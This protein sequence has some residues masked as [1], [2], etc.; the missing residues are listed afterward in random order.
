MIRTILLVILLHVRTMKLNKFIFRMQEVFVLEKRY[1]QIMTLFKL[2]LFILK[3][4]HAFACLWLYI[5][6]EKASNGEVS[7][8]SGMEDTSWEV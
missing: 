5:G 1:L 4:S 6:R 3:V 7:W 8:L 2:L